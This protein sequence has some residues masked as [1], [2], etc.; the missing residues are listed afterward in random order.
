MKDK[1]KDAKLLLTNIDYMCFEVVPDV[2]CQHPKFSFKSH[3]IRLLLFNYF[4][5]HSLFDQQKCRS[6][7]GD[8]ISYAFYLD[9]PLCIAQAT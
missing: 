7:V 9:V 2:S 6:Y 1:L 8:A 3:C 5:L 4:F